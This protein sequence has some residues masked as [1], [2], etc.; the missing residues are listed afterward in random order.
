MGDHFPQPARHS[1]RQHAAGW[2]AGKIPLP[3]GPTPQG[4][5][6]INERDHKQRIAAGALKNQAGKILA[7]GSFGKAQG[8]ILRD[9]RQRQ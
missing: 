7:Q 1:V 9:F 3:P 2:R 8:E 5:K 4:K 6:V